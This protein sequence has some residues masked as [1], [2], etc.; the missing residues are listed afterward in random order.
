MHKE[1][2]GQAR[3][4]VERMRNDV[5]EGSSKDFP[6]A[7]TEEFANRCS[8]MELPLAKMMEIANRRA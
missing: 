4:D 7:K 3:D 5:A 2:P 8:K 1:I 6:L